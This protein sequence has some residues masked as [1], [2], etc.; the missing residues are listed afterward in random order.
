MGGSW[1][2]PIHRIEVNWRPEGKA[3]RGNET[4]GAD[5]MKLNWATRITILRIVLIIPFVSCML[6]INDPELSAAWQITMR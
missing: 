4:N 6:K 5:D 3:D 1:R 2:S